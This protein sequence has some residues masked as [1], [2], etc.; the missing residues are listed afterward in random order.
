MNEPGPSEILLVTRIVAIALDAAGI[1]YFV[2]GS[3]ASAIYGQARSTRDVDI[4]AA[5]LPR[6]IEPLLAALGKEF[7]ADLRVVREAVIARRSF[8]II[9]LET[10]IKADVFVFNPDDFG[11]SQISR[12]TPRQLSQD[13]SLMVYFASAEDIV[14]AKLRW[15]RESGVGSDRQWND[16]LGVLKVQG[17]SLDREYLKEW[18]R[19]LK[20]TDLLQ[21][22]LDDA[23]LP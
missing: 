14:L 3:V 5:M 17:A 4:I 23:G 10:M 15:Y 1:R 6:H 16:V 19:G 8:N 20:L 12:R 22:A 2:G 18:A 13:D 11:R 21:K 7:H 9:H